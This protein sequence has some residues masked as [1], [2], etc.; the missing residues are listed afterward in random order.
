MANGPLIPG[1][2]EFD[3]PRKGWPAWVWWLIA[4]AVLLLVLVLAAGFVGGVGPLRSLGQTTTGL[5]AVKY[6]PTAAANVIQVALQMPAS[7]LCRDDE[8]TVTAYER[9]DRV[10]VDSNVT[11]PRRSSCPV[12]NVGGDVRWVDVVLQEPLGT[13]QVVRLPDRLALPRESG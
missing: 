11:R 13:R 7:G 2:R 6:R 5:S 3:R 8:V 4:G 12:T 9:S 1:M 10:E